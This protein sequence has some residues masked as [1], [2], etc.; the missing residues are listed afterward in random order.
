MEFFLA[1][2]YFPNNRL[3]LNEDTPS[4]WCD[5]KGGRSAYYL[6][7]E[8]ALS[9]G[10]RIDLIGIQGHMIYEEDMKIQDILCNPMNMFETLDLYSEF[11]IPIQITEVTIPALTDDPDN[12]KLQA[13]WL[14]NLYSI[15]FSHHAVEAVTYWDM[16]DGYE[17]DADVI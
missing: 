7:I 13:E 15:W 17:P 12:E 5:R 10:A 8:R 4:V 14:K 9:R 16:V 6:Q 2:K 11:N 3:L 1:E